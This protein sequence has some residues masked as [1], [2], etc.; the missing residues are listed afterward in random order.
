MNGDWFSKSLDALP[1]PTFWGILALRLLNSLTINTF[2][3]AD[4]YWQALEPAHKAVFGYGHLTWEWKLGLRSYLHPLLYML[5]YWIVKK[6]NLDYNAVL[7]APKII[8]ALIAAIGEYYL[9]HYILQKTKN[10]RFSKLVTYL[11]IFSAWNWY[12]WCRSFANSFELSLTIVSLYYLQKK[13]MLACL[14]LAAITCLIRPTNAIFWLYYLP[15]VFLRQPKYILLATF[16]ALTTLSLDG[17]LNYIFYSAAKFPLLNFF[18][19]NVSDNLSAF[20]GVSRL[21]FYFLQAIPV[22]LLNY[23]PFFI[24]GIASNRF[25]SFKILL[26]FYI[27]IFTLIGH[28]EFRFIYP[29]MPMLLT[30]SAEGMIRLSVK[31]TDISMKLIVYLTL[32]GSITLGMYFTHYHEVGEIQI[33][34]LLHDLS[35]QQND[36]ISIGFLAP[37]HSTPFQSHIHTPTSYTEIWFLTCEPPIKSNLKPGVSFSNYMD[38]SDCFYDDPVA[39]MKK[40]FPSQI[41]PSAQID[42]ISEWP[43][44]WPEYVVMFDS[45]WKNKEVSDF[46]S[47]HYHVIERIWNAPFHWDPRRTGDVLLLKCSNNE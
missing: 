25:W 16:A 28:K 5:S 40:N 26:L 38:E 19:F 24:Y 7:V 43:H 44:Q 6:L 15:P 8:N 41:L 1:I 31:F 20:Y 9:Y 29:L 11:S 30:F 3:Q 4:E 33:T 42:F 21:E 14:F 12:C 2:F 27:G 46:L 32:I 10:Q 23:L 47:D 22:L 35:V 37:C 18:Q 34:K 36:K 13:K 39:F 45:L 17:A